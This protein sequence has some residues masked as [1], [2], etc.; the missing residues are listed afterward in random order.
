[1]NVVI[2]QAVGFMKFLFSYP[3]QCPHMLN[4][5]ITPVLTRLLSLVILYLYSSSSVL[6][7]CFSDFPVW[8]IFE[9]TTFLCGILS[10]FLQ[11]VYNPTVSTENSNSQA[12][13]ARS[14]DHTMQIQML[15][16][17][18]LTTHIWQLLHVVIFVFSFIVKVILNGT[19]E[20][21]NLS[22]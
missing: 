17:I 11:F 7:A 20:T 9:H 2:G 13:S 3:N 15:S 5:F 10:S 22:P 8:Q 18:S 6:S 14:S 1:M 21:N 4:L 19:S 12:C 16:G